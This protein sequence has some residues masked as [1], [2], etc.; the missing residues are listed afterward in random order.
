MRI[1]SGA[2]HAGFEIKHDLAGHLAQGGHEV[3][4]QSTH[5]TAPVDYPDIAAAVAQTIRNGQ[6][7]RGVLGCDSGAGAAMAAGKFPGIRRNRRNISSELFDSCLI[8]PAARAGVIRT[9]R[10]R[11][12]RRRGRPPA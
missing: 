2:D 7:D 1:A 9:D 4:D 8:I 11:R 5:S 6:A 3:T 10:R 12:A